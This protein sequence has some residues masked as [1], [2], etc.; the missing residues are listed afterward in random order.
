MNGA[1][2]AAA[3][4]IR[5]VEYRTANGSLRLRRDTEVSTL[6]GISALSG[7]ASATKV[8]VQRR[9]HR[10]CAALSRGA[11]W[12]DELE[13]IRDFVSQFGKRSGIASKFDI[14]VR[15]VALKS[16]SGLEDK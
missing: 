5:P 7:Q 1:S 4:P 6:S 9:S 14:L 15:Y 12:N 2:V 13:R 16:I 8:A 10:R 11:P 3:R